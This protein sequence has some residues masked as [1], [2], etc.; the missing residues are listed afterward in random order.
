M[1]FDATYKR[2]GREY[3]ERV[4]YPAIDLNSYLS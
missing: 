2:E 3:G 4:S 1:G